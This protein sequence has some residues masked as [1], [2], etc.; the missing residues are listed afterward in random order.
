MVITSNLDV[1]GAKI[2]N[3]PRKSPTL[4]PILS[5]LNLT[6]IK[7][8]GSS[9]ISFCPLPWSPKRS[10]LF[11]FIYTNTFIM[12][13]VFCP[14]YARNLVILLIFCKE[15][16]L[17]SFSLCNFLYQSV[18]SFLLGPNI[19]LSTLFS[20]RP[21]VY[22]PSFMRAI[23]LLLLLLLLLPRHINNKELN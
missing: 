23:T 17:Q 7:A 15:Y 22:V 18:T 10:R 19:L 21:S 5:S 16:M 13:L 2:H 11:R 12:F 9:L 3:R 6:V 1:W 20:S 4:D 14:A 8:V